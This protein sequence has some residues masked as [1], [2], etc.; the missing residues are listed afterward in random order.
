MP[1]P[2]AGARH[3]RITKLCGFGESL[4]SISWATCRGSSPTP[5]PAARKDRTYH[6]CGVGACEHQLSRAEHGGL[7]NP[8]FRAE[9]EGLPNPVFQ[10]ENGCLANPPLRTKHKSH[11]IITCKNM[12][13]YRTITSDY[14]RPPAKEQWNFQEPGKC[15]KNFLHVCAPL[16]P[17]HIH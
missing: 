17:S 9:N 5:Q 3:E 14:I 11:R 4:T 2:Q 10:A 13:P 15:G 16:T 12:I 8:P 6:F 7:A 1:N